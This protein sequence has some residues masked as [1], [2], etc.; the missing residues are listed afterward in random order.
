MI[1]SYYCIHVLN[2][3]LR[4]KKLEQLKFQVEEKGRLETERKKRLEEQHILD[5]ERKERE[6]FH[7]KWKNY[8]CGGACSY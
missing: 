2:K 1:L 3:L 7:V 5:K 8:V 4:F 6:V